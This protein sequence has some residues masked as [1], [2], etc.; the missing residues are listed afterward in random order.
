MLPK[1]T[2]D[3]EK[4][5]LIDAIKSFEAEAFRA[6]IVMIWLLTLDHIY[7]FILNNKLTDFNTELA[8]VTDKRVKV[9]IIS[10]K[11]DFGDI[12]EGKFIELCRSARIISNDVRKILDEKLGIRNSAAHPSNIVIGKSKALAVIEDLV[13]ILFLNYKLISLL[14]LCCD[15][16]NNCM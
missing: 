11:D 7:E 3:S 13:N 6:A 16:P 9:T 12:P 15:V 8:K 2:N 14:E 1:L 10:N 5:F 4:S